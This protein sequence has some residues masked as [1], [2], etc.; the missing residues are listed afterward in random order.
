MAFEPTLEC[1]AR[2]FQRFQF[3]IAAVFRRAEHE[4]LKALTFT[5]RRDNLMRLNGWLASC[6][7]LLKSA[8]ARRIN[9][10]AMKRLEA[11][12]RIASCIVNA[13]V[14]TISR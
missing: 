10:T 14:M 6:C 2:R 4:R 12:E 1:S 9:L 8:F 7:R 3:P 13:L 5:R 11:I